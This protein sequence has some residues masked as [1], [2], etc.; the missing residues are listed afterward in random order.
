MVRAFGMKK[1]KLIELLQAIPGNPDVVLYNGLVQDWQGIEPPIQE[2]IYRT[3]RETIA[4]DVLL[5]RVRDGLAQFSDTIPQEE[6]KQ[7][8]RNLPWKLW[9]PYLKEE[10]YDSKPVII[11]E[12]KARGEKTWDRMG[13]IEY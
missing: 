11:L 13:T 5:E 2:R 7:I 6:V 3:N 12:A 9:N 10:F 8:Q 4:R 1:N